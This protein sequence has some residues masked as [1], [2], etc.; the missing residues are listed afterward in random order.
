MKIKYK[1]NPNFNTGTCFRFNRKHYKVI[2]SKEEIERR[3][4]EV[5]MQIYRK[6][7]TKTEIVL[8]SVMSGGIRFGH[9]LST[10]LSL[11]GVKVLEDYIGVSRYRGDKK[12]GKLSLYL[13]T[14]IDA[15]GKIRIVVEDLVD[16]GDT[17]NFVH[18]YFQK[19]KSKALEYF[20]GIVKKGHK[21][22][23]FKIDY[24]ILTGSFGWLVGFG[25]DSF[26]LYRGWLFVA[27]RICIFKKYLKNKTKELN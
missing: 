23:L 21:E 10:E 17:M 24:N 11:L 8:T 3:V 6:Y 27:V 26:G 2:L 13:K 4:K 14:K 19:E 7:G 20:V 22:L 1:I 9:L 15:T 12:T 5:A 25:M 18:K 16:E